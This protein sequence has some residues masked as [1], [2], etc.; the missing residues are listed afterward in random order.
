MSEIETN[1]N[2]AVIDVAKQ[3]VSPTRIDDADA[4]LLVFPPDKNGNVRTVDVEAALAT[5]R[6]APVRAK[7]TVQLGTVDSLINYTLQHKTDGT[8]VWVHP[9]EGKVVAVLNNHAPAPGWGDHRAVL[10]LVVTDEWKFWMGLNGKMVDQQQFANH[11]EEGQK[12]I[13]DPPAA[14]MLEIAQ[15]LHAQVGA[16][17][18]SAIRLTD[19]NVQVKYVEETKATAGKAGDLKIPATFQVGIAPFQG[20]DP[21]RITARLRYRVNGGDLKIGYI[22]DRPQDVVKACL[23]AIAEKLSEHF[24]QVYVGIPR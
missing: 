14:T 24:P 6:D 17:F 3:A 15:T 23:D 19:G 16:D 10:N 8:D 22:L 1:E 7:G 11:I 4:T 2:Q 12:E 9:T 5:H 18:T 13:V 21:F 20:E